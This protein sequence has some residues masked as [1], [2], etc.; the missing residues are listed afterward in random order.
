ME[1]AGHLRRIV[2]LAVLAL[3]AGCAWGSARARDFADLFRLEG[4]I[5]YGLQAHANAGEL[6]HAGA[7]SSR[8][9]TAGLLYGR[10]VEQ[11][12]TEHHLP[13]S[14][15]QSFIHPARERAHALTLHPDGDVDYHRCFLIFPGKI[16]PGTLTKDDIHYLDLEAGFLAGVVGAEVGFS[17]GELLDFLLG[18]FRFSEDWKFLDPA[19]D[20]SFEQREDKRFW[21]PRRTR[22]GIVLPD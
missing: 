22:E 2:L 16:N 12:V 18:L 4:Q 17:P 21:V 3:P 11:S 20:D 8:R 15:V 13:V 7:G 10:A 19:G 5:G 1:G 6:L 9:W 14:L